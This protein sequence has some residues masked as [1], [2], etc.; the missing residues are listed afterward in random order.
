MFEERE[1]KVQAQVEE[2]AQLLDEL[3]LLVWGECP[4]LL[5][6]DSGGDSDLDFRILRALS[7]DEED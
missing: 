3:R 6:E 1:D 7:T 5:N 2:L 4:S